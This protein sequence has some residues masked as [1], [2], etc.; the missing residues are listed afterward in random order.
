MAI[1]MM[2]IALVHATRIQVS[3]STELWGKINTLKAGDELLIRGGSYTTNVAGYYKLVTLRGNLT[4]P[5]RVYALSNETVLISGDSAGSQNIV[6]LDVEYAVFENLQFTLG[7]RGVRVQHAQHSQF[8]NLKVNNAGDAAF[9]TND[10]GQTYLNLT[11]RGLEISNTRGTG[12]CFYLGCNNAACK[13]VDC[14]IENNYCHDTTAASQ[15]DGIELKTGSYGNIIR[16]NV[17]F[18]TKYPGITLYSTY[19]TNYDAA[20][21]ALAISKPNI[22]EGNIIWTTIDNGIQVTGN[23]IIRNNIIMNCGASCIAIQTNQGVVENVKLLFNTAVTAGSACLRVTNSGPGIVIANN[24]AYCTTA[25]YAAQALPGDGIVK[26]NVIQGTTNIAT[27]NATLKIGNLAADFQ[28]T[29]TLPYNL[30]P[31]ATSS[32]LAKADSS[33]SVSH[34][35]NGNA[36]SG[37]LDCGAYQKGSASTNP[38]W[39]PV[40]GFKPYVYTPSPQPSPQ[41]SP[42]VSPKTSPKV[43]PKS[44]QRTNIAAIYSAN[45]VLFIVLI[46]TALML[47]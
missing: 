37:A 1:L 47:M 41:P 15:G 42:K 5:I 35:F 31:T 34:D 6:N 16:N 27:A 18:N 45:T 10:S 12:E 36:R 33:Q 40:K 20:E 13:M 25:L 17:I 7:S 30:F 29:T 32:V 23:A 26:N 43:S 9:T 44:S 8:L 28:Q 4:H 46:S 14:V 2:M 19:Y 38:G 22:V 24:A 21:K 11:I 39:I 3:T